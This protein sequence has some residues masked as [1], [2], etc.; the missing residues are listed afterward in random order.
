MLR[1][2]NG[3]GKSEGRHRD[4]STIYS[5]PREE[6]GMRRDRCKERKMGR[7]EK[8]NESSSSIERNVYIILKTILKG[9]VQ[10]I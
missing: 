1:N 5:S 7:V 9:T 3:R 10:A 8:V 2:L 6:G 4:F